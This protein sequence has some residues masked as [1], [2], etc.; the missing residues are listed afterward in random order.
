MN[1]EDYSRGALLAL[2]IL[3]II[4]LTVD[5]LPLWLDVFIGSLIL[6]ILTLASKSEE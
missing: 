2:V 5:L 6:I 1:N 4:Y 3:Y